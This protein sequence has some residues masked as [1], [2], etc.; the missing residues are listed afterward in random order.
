MR[1]SLRSVSTA[2]AAG[3]VVAITLTAWVAG[4]AAFANAFAS[5]AERQLAGA[6]RLG[7]EFLRMSQHLPADSVARVLALAT[8][9]RVS[10]F[11]TALAL[12]ADSDVRPGEADTLQDRSRR[13]E[14]EGALDRGAATARRRSA[15]DRRRYVFGAARLHWQG[16]PA[17]IRFGARTDAL[18]RT[19]GQAALVVA[20]AVLGASIVAVA[21]LD[22]FARSLKRSLAEVRRW[23]GRAASGDGDDERPELS[24][25]TE[26][27]QMA[28]AADRLKAGL[29]AR[30]AT[31]GRERDELAQLV[32]QVGEG[33]VALDQE[34]RIFQ[35]NPAARRLLGLAEVAPLTPV[36]AVVRDPALRDL[37]EE[38]V[39]R[40]E[41]RLELG[42]GDRELDVRTKRGADGGAVVLLVDVT[43]IRRLDA[44][45]SDFV[46]NAS[47]ELKTP[48]TVI[49]AA[50][51]AIGD[52]GL[53]DE[54]R[55]RFVRAIGTNAVRLQRLVD[56]LLDLS[57]YES[58]AWRPTRELVAMAS[59]ARTAWQDLEG[60]PGHAEVTFEVHGDGTA[61]GD[62]AAV[63]QIFRNLFENALRYVS[64]ESARIT[65]GV[66]AS[67]DKVAVTVGDNG[68]GMP[69]TALPRIFERFYRVDGARS[70]A[71]GGTGLGLAIVRHLVVSMGGEVAAASAL[72]E[73]TA[74]TF[75]LPQADA[76][77]ATS[78]TGAP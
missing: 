24:R 54:L 6:A 2:W 69:E 21:A 46:A 72:G 1:L 64:R 71:G 27:A 29:N 45:R 43:E 78:S 49:R 13:T 30:I 4:R 35:I 34:A 31:A 40:R 20:L 50:A 15:S 66:R 19:A 41:G 36:G 26:V 53:S 70:R 74:I 62:G 57:R 18:E 28:L 77:P 59:V 76:V 10:V 60:E 75:D 3:A 55:T 37:L 44:V 39:A 14:I 48:L 5:R 16:E 23:L 22:R 32:D 67:D 9:H 25:T 8:E 7:A 63:Y 73:G 58:G 47:H 56:D 42:V 68:A 38:S 33:L 11:D 17:T 52:A 12:V 51:E 61:R 65:V